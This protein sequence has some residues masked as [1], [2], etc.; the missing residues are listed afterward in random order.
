MQGSDENAHVAAAGDPSGFSAYDPAGREHAV[1]IGFIGR[2][3]A[4]R[5]MRSTPG[6]VLGRGRHGFI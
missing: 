1:H 4:D 6:R 3:Y 5:A 2:S